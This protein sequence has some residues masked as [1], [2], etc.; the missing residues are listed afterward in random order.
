M[1]YFVTGL[2]SLILAPSA[3][4]R[5][6]RRAL[7]SVILI[8]VIFMV[9]LGSFYLKENVSPGTSLL[10]WGTCF[11]LV[12]WS[13]FLAYLDVKSIK[14]DFRAQKKEIFLSTFSAASF[15][16]KAREKRG[17]HPPSREGGERCE[18]DSKNGGRRE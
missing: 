6:Q 5:R 1:R 14:H 10:F 12:V 13:V 11:L 17:V 4:T 2:L 3:A 15:K 9:L 7:G 16:K 8:V 18:A